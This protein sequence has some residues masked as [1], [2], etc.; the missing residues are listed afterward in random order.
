MTHRTHAP[1]MP[2]TPHPAEGHAAADE[3]AALE[4]QMDELGL[5]PAE[6]LFLRTLHQTERQ[7]NDAFDEA[8]QS[9]DL[10]QQVSRVYKQ[11]YRP[12]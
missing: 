6:R 7:I 1:A 8:Q 10:Q 2:A 9:G 5:S 11:M 12:D 3:A 4:R